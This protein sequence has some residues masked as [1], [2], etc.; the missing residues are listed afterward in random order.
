MADLAEGMFKLGALR[1]RPVAPD[2]K[3]LRYKLLRPFKKAMNGAATKGGARPASS[4]RC[5]GSGYGSTSRE[6]SRSLPAVTRDAPPHLPV[7]ADS[8]S[9]PVLVQPGEEP[10][11]KAQWPSRPGKRRPARPLDVPTGR[12]IRVEF[13]VVQAASSK[14]LPRLIPLSRPARD[15]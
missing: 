10:Q 5:R 3:D 13:K 4:S 12:V 6:R 8:L 14:L 7:F 2:A 9:Q 1:K 15:S 11:T